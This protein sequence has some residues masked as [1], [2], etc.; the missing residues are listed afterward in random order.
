MLCPT[1]RNGH[2]CK[3]RRCPECGQLWAADVRV[4]LFRNLESYDGEVTLSAV[5]APGQDVL[6][7]DR[8]RCTHALGEVCSGKKGCRVDRAAARQWN[9]T[10]PR[11]WRELHRVAS[12]RCR[13]RYGAGSLVLVGRV[14]EFQAR[15]VLHVHPLL[16]VATPVNR[17]AA[18]AY[19]QLLQDL[20]GKYGFG[21]SEGR[22]RRMSGRACAAYVSSYFVGGKGRKLDIRET[23][24]HPEVP[25]HVVHVSTR[26]TQRT[27]V[28]MRYLRR[29]RY[30]HMLLES[31][32]I[33][34]YDGDQVD[35]DTG[36]LTEGRVRKQLVELGVLTT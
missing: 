2:A 10:A 9:R 11:R 28:T 7:W 33:R 20:G 17:A 15:G 26:L 21:F 8:S 16:G 35:V 13:R 1:P 25:G 3:A 14:W 27:R 6:P 5:T 31:G 30:L 12:Q 24:R 18:D 32:A 22:V 4:K 36:E 34:I 29:R 19:L 23:V